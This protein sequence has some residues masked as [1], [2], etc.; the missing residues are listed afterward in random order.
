MEK[1]LRLQNRVA[2]RLNPNEA[3]HQELLKIIDAYSFEAAAPTQPLMLAEIRIACA[4]LL[5]AAQKVLKTEWE[6]RESCR[7]IEWQGLI[8]K[9]SGHSICLAHFSFRCLCRAADL[10]RL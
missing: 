4:T 1:G 8:V 7:L 2:R 9:S 10:C 3:A 5:S 6:A